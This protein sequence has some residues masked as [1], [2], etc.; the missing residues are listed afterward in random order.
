MGFGTSTLLSAKLDVSELLEKSQ[1]VPVINM[2]L[3]I[4]KYI[5]PH[6][7]FTCQKNVSGNQY[8]MLNITVFKTL[9][10]L[11]GH[12]SRYFKTFPGLADCLNK[13][14]TGT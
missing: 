4:I 12:N 3:S 11:N 1:W 6:I 7:Q 10:G 9:Q 14:T 2:I 13:E 8:K 5:G